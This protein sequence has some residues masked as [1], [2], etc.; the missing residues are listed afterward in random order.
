MATDTGWHLYRSYKSGTKHVVQWLANAARQRCNMTEIMPA[1]CMTPSPMRTSNKTDE[2]IITVSAADLLILARALLEASHSTFSPPDGL[3]DTIVVLATVISGRQECAS[4]HSKSDLA[5]ESHQHFIRV[6]ESLASILRCVQ[7]KSQQTNR[8][9]RPSFSGTRPAINNAFGVLHVEQ[10]DDTEASE[11]APVPQTTTFNTS[12]LCDIS[13]QSQVRLETR[14]DDRDFALRSLLKECYDVRCYLKQVWSARH[15]GSSPVSLSVAS[16]VTENAIALLSADVNEFIEEFPE[17][18]DFERIPDFVEVRLE[19]S[20]NGMHLSTCR[21]Q[22]SANGE[23]TIDTNELFCMPALTM[24]HLFRIASDASDEERREQ[25]TMHILAQSS[26]GR[27]ILNN[28]GDLKELYF[29]EPRRCSAFGGCDAFT[30]LLMTFFFSYPSMP[31]QLVFALQI[32]LVIY[33]AL[34]DLAGIDSAELV[35]QIEH[36]SIILSDHASTAL[37]R[38]DWSLLGGS[39]SISIRHAQILHMIQMGIRT[40]LRASRGAP[41][42]SGTTPKGNHFGG[43][44]M[45]NWLQCSPTLAGHMSTLLSDQLHQDGVDTCNQ[46][47]VVHSMAHL[48]LACQQLSPGLKWPDMDWIISRQGRKAFGLLQSTDTQRGLDE[49]SSG[50]IEASARIFGLSLGVKLSKYATKRRN[51]KQRRAARPILPSTAACLSR[52][53]RLQVNSTYLNARAQ[54]AA[55]ADKLDLPDDLMLRAACHKSAHAVSSSPNR[56]DRKNQNGV[57][58][59]LSTVEV[60]T[61]LQTSLTAEE[62]DKLFTYHAF[63]HC[64]LAIMNMVVSRCKELKTFRAKMKPGILF[65]EIVD[66]LL[67]EAAEAEAA[68]HAPTTLLAIT[69]SLSGVLKQLGEQQISLMRVQKNMRESTARAQRDVVEDY[70]RTREVFEYITQSKLSLRGS[71]MEVIPLE[72]ERENV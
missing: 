69:R 70:V 51:R 55:T 26:L 37:T 31:I 58:D 43:G 17:L 67:W 28:L 54:C 60:L 38:G 53:S 50:S 36:V 65:Y 52:T 8:Q 47:L 34:D 20:E 22:V 48:Y 68:C 18:S 42:P 4:W 13:A 63:F 39:L 62:P 44:T 10:L 3:G 2:P 33:N 32:Q 40:P 24:L 7:T 27:D 1:L 23:S 30:K 19:V 5:Q 9:N 49:S 35:P 16:Q 15:H 45:S 66:E 71:T 14:D 57:Q 61:S 59:C 11:P 46:G 6:L 64:C 25:A 56:K 21:G 29:D 12:K 41:I 72:M